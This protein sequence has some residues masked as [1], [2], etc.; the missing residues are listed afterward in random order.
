MRFVQFVCMALNNFEHTCRLL[1]SQVFRDA[2]QAVQ[3]GAGNLQEVCRQ[4]GSRR[5][6]SR[7]R[8][9][10]SITNIQTPMETRHILGLNIN[11]LHA[12]IFLLKSESR[13][14]NS[15]TGSEYKIFYGWRIA[16]GTQTREHGPTS[17]VSLNNFR[18][19]KVSGF[20]GLYIYISEKNRK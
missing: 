3:S 5:Q 18:F 8:R 6:V 16:F 7:R 11:F 12:D 2:A 9:G 17:S 14:K 1:C 4:H 20:L 13:Q 15:N 19:L 10:R